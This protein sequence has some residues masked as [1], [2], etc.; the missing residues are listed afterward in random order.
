MFGPP[1]NPDARAEAIN[2]LG[3]NPDQAETMGL[4]GRQ[5]AES[6]YN[7]ERYAR[8]LHTFFKSI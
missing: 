1:E 2:F 4:R 6:H 8:D 7:T 3:D 5:L